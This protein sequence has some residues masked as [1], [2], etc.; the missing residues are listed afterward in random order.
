MSNKHIYF[1]RCWVI[2]IVGDVDIRMNVDVIWFVWAHTIQNRGFVFASVFKSYSKSS[3]CWEGFGF[4][5]ICCSWIATKMKNVKKS[6]CCW[7]CCAICA[8][9]SL[10]VVKGLISNSSEFWSDRQCMYR[11]TDSADE[12]TADMMHTTRQMWRCDMWAQL[13]QNLICFWVQSSDLTSYPFIVWTDEQ[14]PLV[15]RYPLK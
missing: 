13:Q 9:Y 12:S 7:L 3:S 14:L 5:S 4:S 15:S 11:Q 1:F 6:H 10:S 2:V 8:F